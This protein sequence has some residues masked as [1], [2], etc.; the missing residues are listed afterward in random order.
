MAAAPHLAMEYF[1]SMSGLS[2]INVPYKGVGP[3]LVD[4]IAGHVPLMMGSTSALCRT[5]G[6]DACEH[7]A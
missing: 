1:L 6:A 3:A 7:M 4:V 5:S 2:M